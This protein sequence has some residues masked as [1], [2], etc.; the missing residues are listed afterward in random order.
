MS[1]KERAFKSPRVGK[2]PL[3]DHLNYHVWRTAIIDHLEASDNYN[4]FTAPPQIKTQNENTGFKPLVPEL[5]SGD[6]AQH[7]SKDTF[8]LLRILNVDQAGRKIRFGFFCKGRQH[9]RR[10]FITLRST[11]GQPISAYVSALQD[12]RF[13]HLRR[14]MTIR[15][16][17]SFSRASRQPTTFW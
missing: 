1:S 5:P 10:R 16:R 3:L 14:L 11:Q 17:P 4:I 9:L 12:I 7:Q 2:I 6:H 15:S 13:N 8:Q